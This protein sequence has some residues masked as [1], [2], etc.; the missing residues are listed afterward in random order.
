M[1]AIASSSSSHLII[2]F[3]HCDYIF[4]GIFDTVFENKIQYTAIH[5]AYVELVESM[6]EKSISKKI[7]A[8]NSSI[9]CNPYVYCNDNHSNFKIR[10]FE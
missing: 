8:S 2:K 6:I 4:A 3:I 7:K 10:I 1:L 9:D 5:N